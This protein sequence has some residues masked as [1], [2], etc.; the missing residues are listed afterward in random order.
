[1]WVDLSSNQDPDRDPE[2]E[3]FPSLIVRT[4]G[5]KPIFLAHSPILSSESRAR[6]PAGMYPA[7]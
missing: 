4:P 7:W 1:M 5:R 3:E 2:L 6:L